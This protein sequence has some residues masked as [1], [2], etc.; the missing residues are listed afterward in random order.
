M[1]ELM[2]NAIRDC[3]PISDK[4]VIAYVSPHAPEVGA[5]LTQRGVPAFAAAESC[6]AALGA[7]LQAGRWKAPA[8]AASRSAAGRG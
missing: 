6:T 4:P 3:L 5:L 2:A 1:P 7:L 8:E